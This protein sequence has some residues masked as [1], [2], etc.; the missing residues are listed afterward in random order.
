MQRK[1]KQ[2]LVKNV[3]EMEGKLSGIQTCQQKTTTLSKKSFMEKED[4]LK[5]FAI[6]F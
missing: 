4:I 6:Y 3:E 1:T 5:L 2:N